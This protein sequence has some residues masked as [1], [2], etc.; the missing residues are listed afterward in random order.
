[1]ASAARWNSAA[2]FRGQARGDQVRSHAGSEG[3]SVQTPGRQVHDLFGGA[4]AGRQQAGCRT[5]PGQDF[6]H[7][8]D[9]G[10]AVLARV[11][12]TAEVGG[13]IRRHPG[14]PRP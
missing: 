2:A 1:M 10:G 3:E 4:Q 12:Q 14:Q 11:I 7:G 13:G 8:Q 6:V 5:G 9:L